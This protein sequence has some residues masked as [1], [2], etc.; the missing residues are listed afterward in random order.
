MDR[1]RALYNFLQMYIAVTSRPVCRHKD[2]TWRTPQARKP[3]CYKHSILLPRKRIYSGCARPAVHVVIVNRV[4]RD[5]S[6]TDH[7]GCH[8]LQYTTVRARNPRRH[9]KTKKRSLLRMRRSVPSNRAIKA[10]CYKCN[11]E[12][13]QYTR[14]HAHM[15]A[16][17]KTRQMHHMRKTQRSTHEVYM[18]DTHG[19]RVASR[20][21]H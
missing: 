14:T 5:R 17:H 15:N 2:E 7:H 16:H 11:K 4:L 1:L 9:E 20:P 12:K 6:T 21:R 10:R 13:I 19:A 18:D 8:K 3:A